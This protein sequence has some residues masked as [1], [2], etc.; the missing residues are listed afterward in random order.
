MYWD[1]C[2]DV[3]ERIASGKYFYQIEAGDYAAVRKM[4]VEK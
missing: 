1:R 2:N 4:I 3:A